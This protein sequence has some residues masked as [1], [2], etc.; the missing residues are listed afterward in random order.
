MVKTLSETLFENF[1]TAAGISWKKIEETTSRTPDF[2]LIT[3]GRPIIVEVKEI[4]ANEQEQETDRLRRQR[5]Y[6]NVLRFVPGERVRSKIAAASEQIKS[7][8]QGIYPSMLV[9][10]DLTRNGHCEPY[11]VRVGMYALEQVHIDFRR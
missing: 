8:S 10:T 7:R 2:E 11:H 1:C 9:L 5:G 6:G 4:T 3:S